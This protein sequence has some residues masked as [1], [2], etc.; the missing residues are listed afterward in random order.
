MHQDLLIGRLWVPSLGPVLV[1]IAQD[2][3]LD[4][5]ELAATCSD[6]LGLPQAAERLRELMRTGHAPRLSKRQLPA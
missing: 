2:A 4:L 6:L 3:V 1:A 5:S